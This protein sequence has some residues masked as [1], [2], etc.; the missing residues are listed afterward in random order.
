MDKQENNM[1]PSPIPELL[2]SSLENVSLKIKLL[3]TLS[4]SKKWLKDKSAQKKGDIGGIKSILSSCIEPPSKQLIESSVYA[5]QEVGCLDEKEL[6]TPLGY[7]LSKLPVG[8]VRLGKM[9]IYGVIFECLT[10]ILVIAAVLTGKS[11]YRASREKREFADSIKQKY[12]V[13]KSDLI[14]SS[15]CW[16]SLS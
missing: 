7:H 15:K 5:L 1:R 14:T 3:R 11:I 4:Q 2:R 9:L 13:S 6:L 10:P 12:Y 16:Q 8:N